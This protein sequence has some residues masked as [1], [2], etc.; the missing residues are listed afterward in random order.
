MAEESSGDIKKKFTC[1]SFEMLYGKDP[2][3]SLKNL[4]EQVEKILDKYRLS[5]APK[6]S[7]K[8][9]DDLAFGM[10]KVSACLDEGTLPLNSFEAA[11]KWL[12]LNS[13][14]PLRVVRRVLES[15]LGITKDP[16]KKQVKSLL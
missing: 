6:I 10:S 16:E 14:K 11:V 8:E 13:G 2:A 1:A 12:S 7:K 15:K 3:E 5:L 4:K 9:I